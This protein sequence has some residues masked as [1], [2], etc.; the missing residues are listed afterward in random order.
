[1]KN[2]GFGLM[3]LPITKKTVRNE[4]IDKEKSRCSASPSMTRQR[5]LTKS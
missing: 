3:R 1:M 4:K 2:L 5:L